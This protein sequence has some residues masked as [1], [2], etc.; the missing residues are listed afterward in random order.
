MTR[1]SATPDR[2]SDDAVE[3]SWLALIGRVVLVIFGG[4]AAAAGFVTGASVALPLIGM[5]RSEAVALAAM[6]GFVV[7]LV[8][9]LWGFAERRLW[10]LCLGLAL[11]AGGGFGVGSLM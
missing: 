8:L 2:D 10:R 7:Y 11:L 5:V 6:L 1:Q 9:L 4:Y 3:P